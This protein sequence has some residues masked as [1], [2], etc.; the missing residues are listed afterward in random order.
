[1]ILNG[2]KS[3]P[4]VRS[5]LYIGSVIGVSRYLLPNIGYWNI[6]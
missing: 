5:K 1:M 6:G 2:K 4:K 3:V